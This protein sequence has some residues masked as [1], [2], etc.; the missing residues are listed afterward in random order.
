MGHFDTTEAL[1]G[2]ELTENQVEMDRTRLESV[3]P[4]PERGPSELDEQQW[5]ENITCCTSVAVTCFG[6][7]AIAFL[8]W[9]LWKPD[10]TELSGTTAATSVTP[11]S[12]TQTISATPSA[13]P[14]TT[15]QPTVTSTPALPTSTQTSQPSTSPTITPEAIVPE[16]C[17]PVPVD[18]QINCKWHIVRSGECLYSIARQFTGGINLR[19]T[20]EAIKRVNGLQSDIIHP[21]NC[22]WIPQ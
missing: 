18:C 5:R 16:A 9:K 2:Q 6:L 1:A 11:P 4:L 19:E 15:P 7:I 8:L 13:T 20:V 17:K 14:S 21:G 12:P 22:L 10:L 3:P